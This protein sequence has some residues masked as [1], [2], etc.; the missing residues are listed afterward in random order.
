MSTDVHKYI[1]NVLVVI[2]IVIL[3]T[4]IWGGFK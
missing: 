4:V 2:I 3:G 1:C